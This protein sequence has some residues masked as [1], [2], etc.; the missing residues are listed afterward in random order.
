LLRHA[1]Y[2]VDTTFNNRSFGWNELEDLIGDGFIDGHVGELG[3][4]AGLAFDEPDMA[5]DDSS[6]SV[7]PE[8]VV[9]PP[10]PHPERHK[11]MAILVGRLGRRGIG[12][13]TPSPVDLVLDRVPE[14][15]GA[16]EVGT[17][18]NQDAQVSL[19]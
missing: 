13:P 6:R 12:P 2:L 9:D 18:L 17:R 10:E 4:G 3:D 7:E 5:K 14:S 15:D 16:Q 1:D 11:R 19:A 8:L